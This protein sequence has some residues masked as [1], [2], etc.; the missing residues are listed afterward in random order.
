MDGLT[1][2]LINRL[3]DWDIID[4]LTEIN[5]Y[6]HKLVDWEMDGRWL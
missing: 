2:K 1:E 3:I 6:T 4:W 5:M